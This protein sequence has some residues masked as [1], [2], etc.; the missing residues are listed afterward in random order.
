M[1]W[2]GQLR[3]IE[4]LATRVHDQYHPGAGERDK[5][6]SWL[7]VNVLLGFL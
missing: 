1:S 2:L 5:Q 7:H 4:A 6:V 3:C